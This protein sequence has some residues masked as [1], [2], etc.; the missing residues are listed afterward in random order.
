[1]LLLNIGVDSIFN[2][3]SI[4]K[5]LGINADDDTIKDI[6]EFIN[7]LAINKNE[8]YEL[9]NNLE[10]LNKNMKIYNNYLKTINESVKHE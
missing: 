7:F 1:M 5:M 3:G 10:E 6:E 4:I 2:L 8:I 9:F